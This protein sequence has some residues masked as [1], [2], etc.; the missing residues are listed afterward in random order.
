MAYSS[1]F[2]PHLRISYANASPTGAA[3]EAEY[4]EIGLATVCDPEVVRE[5]LDEALPPG[6]DV[7]AVAE[8]TPQSLTDL[9][10]ASLWEIDLIEGEPSVLVAAVEAFLAREAVEVTRMTKSGLRTFDARVAVVELSALEGLRLSLL[11][12]HGTPLVRP[13]DVVTGLRLVAP[14]LATD[15]PPLISRIEQGPFVGG[16]ITDPL[17]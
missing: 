10:Q 14:E 4:L 12:L 17:A 7:L 8:A 11:S 2:N 16:K 3:T 5:A 1:G 6:L 9:L 13:D 15:Q